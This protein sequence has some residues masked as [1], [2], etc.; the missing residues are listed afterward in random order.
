MKKALILTWE[1]FQDVELLYCYYKLLE[2]FKVD[3]A[4]N[5]LG[6]IYGINGVKIKSN[7]IFG[8][9]EIVD[10]NNSPISIDDYQLVL[11]VGG[12]LSVEYAR[13]N[14]VFIQTLKDFNSKGKI[15]ASVCHGAQYLIEA[16]LT[17]GKKISGYYSIKKD[18]ENSGAEYVKD[19]VTDGNIITAP[20][21]DYQTKWMMEVVKLV[22]NKYENDRLSDS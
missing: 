11:V 5:K 6:L 7:L 16:D 18:I 14:K 13:Q 10:Q 2:E 9:D 4:S 12:L 15:I 1:K 3:V 20:H 22:N 21:Y 19:V 17:K 8:S